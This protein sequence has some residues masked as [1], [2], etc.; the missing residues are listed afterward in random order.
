MNAHF[1][2]TIANRRNIAGISKFKSINTRHDSTFG[3][4]IRERPQPLRKLFGLA[5]LLH[6]I[7]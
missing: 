6:A 1:A 5:D 7:M 4:G 3:A 2:H